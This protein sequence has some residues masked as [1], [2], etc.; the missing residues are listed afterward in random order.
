MHPTQCEVVGVA[1][2]DGE[3]RLV[4]MR[5]VAAGERLFELEGDLV[6]VPTRYSVQVGKSLHL[7][8]GSEYPLEE[9]YARFYWRFMN[10]HCEPATM[11][12][13]R[14]VIALRDLEPADAV[15]FNYNTTEA[16]MAESFQCRC[17]S[18]R[19]E[20]TIRGA[21]HLAASDVERL[22]PLMAP[23]LFEE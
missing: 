22:R 10:H 11:I 1:E 6:T 5:S 12:R 18:A 2:V 3:L 21:K 7:D 16:D 23:H 15:T 19:C 4:T 8:A 9:V 13:G 14:D 20:G 17:G